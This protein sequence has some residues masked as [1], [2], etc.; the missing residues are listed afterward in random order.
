[1]GFWSEEAILAVLG[2]PDSCSATWFSWFCT[3]FS[4]EFLKPLNGLRDTVQVTA[5]NQSV[6]T[7]IASTFDTGGQN[8]IYGIGG[9]RKKSGDS[10]RTLQFLALYTL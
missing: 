1:M 3:R 8:R 7:K 2:T 5:V 10:Y 4:K 6:S 9:S